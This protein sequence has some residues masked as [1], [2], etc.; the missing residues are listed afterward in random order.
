[1]NG[2]HFCNIL[3]PKQNLALWLV[4]SGLQIVAVVSDVAVSQLDA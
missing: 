2:Y 3:S 4:E 1:M